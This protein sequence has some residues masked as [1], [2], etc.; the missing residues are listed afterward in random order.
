ML[1][2]KREKKPRGKVICPVSVLLQIMQDAVV[3]DEGFAIFNILL[4]GRQ[5]RVGFDS[6]YTRAKGF[7]DPNFFMDEQKFTTFEDFKAGATIGDR[8]FVEI[9]DL[10]EV[11]DVDD[12][13]NLAKFPWYKKFDDYVVGE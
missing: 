3:G 13:Q 5:H 7:F 1:F 12:G 10:V 4:D 11:Y 9:T 6:D 2:K 8:L